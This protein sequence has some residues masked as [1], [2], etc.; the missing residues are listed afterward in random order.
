MPRGIA[1]LKD[2]PDESLH[3]ACEDRSIPVSLK[4]AIPL[5]CSRWSVPE[6]LT[7]T[8]LAETVEAAAVTF[9]NG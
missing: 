9:L 2:A 1:S 6:I 8:V 4:D 7:H 3:S 5:A